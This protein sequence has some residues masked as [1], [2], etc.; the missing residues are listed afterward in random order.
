[1]FCT[2]KIN[3]TYIIYVLHVPTFSP[4]NDIDLESKAGCFILKKCFNEILL[5]VS[6]ESSITLS[7]ILTGDW[8]RKLHDLII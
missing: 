7:L 5:F 8:I 4:M 2:I 6:A 3:T 1:M